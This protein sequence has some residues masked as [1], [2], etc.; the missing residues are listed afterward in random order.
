[1]KGIFVT[2][3][4]LVPA[5]RFR[6]EQFFRYFQ[7]A[8][9]E[10]ELRYA[11]GADYNTAIN[12][13]WGGAYK[14]L[15]RLRRGVQ[16]VTALSDT[17][18]VFLQRIA[19]PQTA[20]F[21]ELLFRQKVPMILDFDDSLWIDGSG[22]A[23]AARERAFIRAAEL[24]D[25]LIAGNSY[26]ADF[27]GM[28]T[29]TTIIP[30]VIDTDIY[31]PTVRSAGPVV[32]GWMGTA[33]NFPSLER[34][35]PALK[36]VL[37]DRPDVRIRIVSNSDFLPL[38]GVQGVEQIRWTPEREVDFLRGFDI[39]LMPL[40]DLAVTRGKCAFKMIQ[41]MAVGTSVVVSDVG[42]N[43][44][45]FDGGDPGFLLDTFDWF[46]ALITLIDD[47]GLREIMGRR[48][49]ARV[50]SAYSISSVL[51]KYL[52]IFEDVSRMR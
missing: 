39:G 48:G 9:V 15:G 34:V 8:G 1:M 18:F 12:H 22:A 44:T 47:P 14:F 52:E 42:A 21:E 10:T 4:L 43:R 41:Y 11:Y 25:W 38:R 26:L 45:V 29:K 31:H 3:G 23:N 2:D 13:W 37:K 24:S 50:V 33:G 40:I 36:Q 32:I 46:D 5:S 6:C 27:V 30:T 19:F 35:V 28:P 7:Q 16:E 51:P 20:V 49:R 17:D